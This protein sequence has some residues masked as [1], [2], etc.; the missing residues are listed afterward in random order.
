MS[1]ASSWT[2][3]K[4]LAEAEILWPVAHRFSL[5]GLDTFGYSDEVVLPVR[6]RAVEP[7]APVAVRAMISYLICS[8]ICVPHDGVLD[9]VVPGGSTPD[10]AEAGLIAR[11]ESLVPGDG[12][13]VG[14]TFERA[15]L[16]EG[17]PDPVLEVVVRSRIPFEA[18]DVLVEG[19]PGFTFARPEVELRNGGTQAVMRLQSGRGFLAEGV[20]EGKWIV[21]TVTDGT[22]SSRCASPGTRSASPRSTSTRSA[23]AAARSFRSTRAA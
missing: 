4:N 14:L 21:L 22:R 18:P 8:N 7:G 17:D 3:S 20:L 16:L 1:Q 23:A 19:P 2:G 5:F 10:S 15:A 12:S 6:A 13:A 11:A 9:L